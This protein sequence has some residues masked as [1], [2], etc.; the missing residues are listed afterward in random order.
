MGWFLGITVERLAPRRCWDWHV[1]EPNEMSMT[2]GPDKRIKVLCIFFSTVW[3]AFV[4]FRKVGTRFSRRGF[5]VLTCRRP[6]CIDTREPRVWT[7]PPRFVRD[8][9]PWWVGHGPYG[10]YYLFIFSLIPGSVCSPIMNITFL[11]LFTVKFKLKGIFDLN[12]FLS[13][14][15]QTSLAFMEIHYSVSSCS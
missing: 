10:C 5:S 3:R 1:K 15:V 4:L 14:S 13:K 7:P 9:V 6:P 12:V 2:W 8:G 11:I